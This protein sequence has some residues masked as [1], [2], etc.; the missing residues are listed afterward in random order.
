MNDI[1]QKTVK[2]LIIRFFLI[3]NIS[4]L[5]FIDAD[6]SSKESFDE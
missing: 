3:L 2:V 4:S 5:I 1:L 6:N